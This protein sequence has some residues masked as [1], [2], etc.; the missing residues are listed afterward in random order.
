M[1]A[2]VRAGGRQEKVA[3][4]DVLT[5]DK[6][7]GE[8]GSTVTFPAVLVVDGDNVVS[9][10]ADLANYE[11]TAE[12]LGAVKGPKINIMHYRSKTGYKRRMG[13][14]QP[15]TQVK[16]TGIKAGK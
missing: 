1:Y 2:I 12:I 10:K 15:Y 3:T 11:V 8:V 6:L 4:G 9:S 13:H 5:V 16:I 7:A 14:R